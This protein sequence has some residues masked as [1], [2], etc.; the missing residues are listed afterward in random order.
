MTQAN[1]KIR[2]TAAG[3]GK[4]GVHGSIPA[5]RFHLHQSHRPTVRHEAVHSGRYR[6]GPSVCRYLPG[7]ASLSSGIPGLVYIRKRQMGA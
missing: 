3:A 4:T 1:Q 5:S 2:R 7:V 6:R